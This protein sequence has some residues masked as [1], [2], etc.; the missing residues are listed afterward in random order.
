MG[1]ELVGGMFGVVGVGKSES[2]WWNYVLKS[3][4]WC[5]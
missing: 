2:R 5:L 1:R 3:L 4:C